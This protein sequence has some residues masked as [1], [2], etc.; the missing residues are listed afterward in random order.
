MALPSLRTL[1]ASEPVPEAAGGVDYHI[2][3]RL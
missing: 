3:M 1:A 2:P